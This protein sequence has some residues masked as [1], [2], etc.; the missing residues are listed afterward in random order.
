MVKDP[1]DPFF[2]L[3][4]I[5]SLDVSLLVSDLPNRHTGNDSN[6]IVWCTVPTGQPSNQGLEH[7]Y[8]WKNHSSGVLGCGLREI[9]KETTPG[10]PKP[11]GIAQEGKDGMS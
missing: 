11:I 4:G 1:P 6:S 10:A 8:T 2:F 7:S 9:K 3:W 5:P